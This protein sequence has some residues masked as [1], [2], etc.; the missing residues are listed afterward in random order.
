M[1]HDDVQR[2]LDRYVEA[3]RSYDPTAIGALFGEDATVPLPA[4]GTRSRVTGRDGDRGRLARGARTSRDAGT[5]RYEPCAI[6]G[7][8]G[9]GRSA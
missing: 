9:D 4:R 2:W 6:D 7:D 3:W 8:A 5:A 1:T